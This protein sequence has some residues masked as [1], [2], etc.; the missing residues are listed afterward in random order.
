[1]LVTV[2]FGVLIMWHQ[3]CTVTD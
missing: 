2:T 3:T 1:L